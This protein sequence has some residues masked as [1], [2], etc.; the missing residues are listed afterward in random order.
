[1][2]QAFSIYVPRELLVAEDPGEPPLETILPEIRYLQ[3]V[4]ERGGTPSDRANM[5]PR[6]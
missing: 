2:N 5:S 1:M 4:L 3:T 6:G